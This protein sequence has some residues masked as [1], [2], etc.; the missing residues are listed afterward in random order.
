V[1]K[2]QQ[3]QISEP[4]A[5]AFGRSPSEVS[6]GE[7]TLNVAEFHS[8]EPRGSVAMNTISITQ[9]IE[10]LGPWFHNLH[11]PD[12][13]QTAPGHFLG[14]FPRYKWEQLSPTVPDDLTGWRVL[15]IG[16]NAGYYSFQLAQR[17]AEVTAIDIDERYLAQARWAANLLDPGR[18]VE[19]R[20]AAIYDLAHE[21]QQYDLIWFMGVLYHLRY[22]LLALDIV[23]TR[24][25]RNMMFQTMT[26]PGEAV[27]DVR[28]DYGL[29]EREIM[30]DPGWPKLA[31]IEHRVAGDPTN[32]WAP[33][34]SAIL[35]LLR[36]AGFGEARR[37]AHEIYWC[38]VAPD[39]IASLGDYDAVFRKS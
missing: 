7:C 24:C 5:A 21:S 39:P 29:Q 34:H 25:R 35:A 10:R 23:R 17:G 3:E 36:S 6:T 30:N 15:D 1:N 13:S 8:R 20:Q 4:F 19:F 37:I 9:N 32:W 27:L 33:N 2:G 26:A 31:F 11:L 18:R 16:C 12:G 14:D 28:E 38:S 22:P